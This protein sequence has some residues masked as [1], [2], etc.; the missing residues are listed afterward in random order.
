MG[1][2]DK[3]LQYMKINDDFKFDEYYKSTDWF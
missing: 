3:F 1:V 2:M